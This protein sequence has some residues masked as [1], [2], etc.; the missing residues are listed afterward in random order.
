MQNI[1]F[2]PFSAR[3]R[4]KTARIHVRSLFDRHKNSFVILHFILSSFPAPCQ[5]KMPV[6]PIIFVEKG[7]ERLRLHGVS[8]YDVQL[9]RPSVK[10][11]SAKRWRL[12]GCAFCKCRGVMHNAVMDE[13]GV[14]N[15][16]KS[17]KRSNCAANVWITMWI[18]WT[19]AVYSY[20]DM[21]D[22]GIN[23]TSAGR[24]IAA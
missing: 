21:Q 1:A 2:L 15:V 24:K 23:M 12:S 16:E 4:N 20:I 3:M 8:A 10:V 18:M 9:W 6:L 14:D 17:K 7:A 11:L 22:D 19:T 13:D 5:R